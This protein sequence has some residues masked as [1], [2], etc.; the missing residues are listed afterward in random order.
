MGVP[1]FT[2]TADHVLAAVF[3][4]SDGTRTYLAYN[5]GTQPR[6]VRFSDGQVLEV[7]ARSLAHRGPAQLL[8]K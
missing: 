8:S 7:G 3:R 2:V 4:R 5:A 6:S 1:D